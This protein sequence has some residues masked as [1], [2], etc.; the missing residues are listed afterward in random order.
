MQVRYLNRLDRDNAAWFTVIITDPEGIVPAWR[1]DLVRVA[2]PVTE[3]SLESHAESLVARILA[4]WN[5]SQ[6][7]PEQ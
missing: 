4:E 7:S 3:A 6:G 5:A 2:L 1:R